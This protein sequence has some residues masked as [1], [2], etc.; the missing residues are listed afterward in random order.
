MPSWWHC[1]LHLIVLCQ[2]WHGIYLEL[3]LNNLCLKDAGFQCQ[4]AKDC[5]SAKNKPLSSC[6]K[7]LF[8]DKPKHSWYK[9]ATVRFNFF[10]HVSLVNPSSS[11]FHI[12][13]HCWRRTLSHDRVTST[14]LSTFIIHLFSKAKGLSTLNCYR[15]CSSPILSSFWLVF[16]HGASCVPIYPV[17]CGIF[18]KLNKY[19]VKLVRLI[20]ATDI[21]FQYRF[22]SVPHP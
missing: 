16:L 6:K 5:K 4:S 20:K 1:L 21:K 14:Q 3:C 17:P 13:N 8:C 10:R 15:F 18:C 22:A 19:S 7:L 12:F 9:V 11:M 2:C